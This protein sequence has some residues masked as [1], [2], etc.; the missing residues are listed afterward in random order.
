MTARIVGSNRLI[1]PNLPPYMNYLTDP[2]LIP[3]DRLQERRVLVTGG[4]GYLGHHLVRELL[5]AGHVVTVFDSLAAAPARHRAESLLKDYAGRYELIQGDL[6]DQAALRHAVQRCDLVYHL[7]GQTDIPRSID[8]PYEDFRINTIGTMHLLETLRLQAPNL[9]LI[10]TSSTQVYGGL[11]WLDVAE[12]HTRYEPV[13][14]QIRRRGLSEST[15]LD[16]STPHGC[17]KGAADQYALDYAST[18]GLRVVVM[19][20]SEV[21]GPGASSGSGENWLMHGLEGKDCDLLPPDRFQVRD[22]LYIDDAI[23]ALLTAGQHLDACSGSVLNIGGGV[24]MSMS[25]EEIFALLRIQRAVR[26]HAAPRARRS[27]HPRWFATDY[28]RF[29]MITGWKPTVS[30]HEGIKMT[31][32]AMPTEGEALAA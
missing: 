26:N 9:P 25:L 29:K 28:S 22:F 8:A 19:R 23:S 7:A 18:Y 21:F 32:Q 12:N 20:L 5:A 31:Q 13:D 3:T 2:T 1:D 30:L 17:A 27:G 16:F 15:P 14:R 10:T 6:G 24:G 4:A 11:P